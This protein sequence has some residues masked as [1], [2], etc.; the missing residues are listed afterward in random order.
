MS[1]EIDI[2]SIVAAAG[3]ACDDPA[4]LLADI[5]GAMSLYRHGIGARERPKLRQHEVAKTITL[6]TQLRSRLLGDPRFNNLCSELARVSEL[7]EDDRLS[8][9]LGVGDASAFNNLVGFL[10]ANIFAAHFKSKAGYTKDKDTGAIK[11]APFVNFVKEVFVEF[12][13][14]PNDRKAI[15]DALTK[16]RSKSNRQN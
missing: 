11:N 1:G 14:K 7:T 5:E 10:L 6:A 8:D 12:E 2:D 13:I 16:W 4:Q 15:A 3:I 9:M